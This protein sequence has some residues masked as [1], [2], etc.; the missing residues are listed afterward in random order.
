MMAEF[1]G[2]FELSLQIFDILSAPMKQALSFP[3]VSVMVDYIFV[4]GTMWQMPVLFLGVERPIGQKV[5]CILS[6]VIDSLRALT[7]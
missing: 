4:E 6:H 5:A 7:L 3:S 2:L 1:S